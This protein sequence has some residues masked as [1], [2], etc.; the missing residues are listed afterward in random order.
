MDHEGKAKHAVT[1]AMGMLAAVSVAAAFLYG[2]SAWIDIAT[3]LGWWAG[4]LFY[5]GSQRTANGLEATS[6]AS[7]KYLGSGRIAGKLRS[8]LL[9]DLFP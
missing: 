1:V 5:S 7:Q 3:L 4:V 8:W 2:A 6:D 9:A